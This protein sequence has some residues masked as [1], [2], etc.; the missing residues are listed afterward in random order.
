MF[1]R[2]DLFLILLSFLTH[3]LSE[4]SQHTKKQNS[5][6]KTFLCANKV[7][8]KSCEG[9]PTFLADFYQ[10]SYQYT[11]PYQKLSYAH[12]SLNEPRNLLYPSYINI[13]F[14]S[15]VHWEFSNLKIRA[16]IRQV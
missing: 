15:I 12:C 4:H 2:I 6:K 11:A 3:K 8:S 14:T 5:N 16:G 7:K 1:F 9:L 10:F 13:L